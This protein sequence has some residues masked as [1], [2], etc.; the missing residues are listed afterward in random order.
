MKI[1]KFLN[2]KRTVIPAV[3]NDW[4]PLITKP[5]SVLSV[6]GFRPSGGLTSSC[7]GEIRACRE[8]EEW[9]IFDGKP[10]W[11]VCQLNLRDAP[12]VPEILNDIA[13]LQIFVSQNHWSSNFDIIDSADAAPKSPFF[14]RKYES[15]DRLIPVTV[16]E[17]NSHFLAFEAKWKEGCLTDYPT[18]DTMPIDFSKLGIG[19]YYDQ[20][21]IEQLYGTKIGGWPCCIQGEPWW[22]YRK[23]GREFEFALQIDSEEKAKC[24]WGDSGSVYIARHQTNRSI[25]AI[26]I[27]CY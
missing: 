6:G 12:F 15:F 7:F 21:D 1:P 27:Q 20:T 25:W 14:I 11:P 3:A 26:D 2:R 24:Y 10:L 5:A 22:D 23:E 9:P 19:D 13:L 18:H 16:P 17:H 4:R 8:D